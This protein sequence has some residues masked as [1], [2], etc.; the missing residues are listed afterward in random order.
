MNIKNILGSFIVVL[1]G[2][3]FFSSLLLIFV[4]DNSQKSALWLG[5]YQINRN[6]NHLNRAIALDPYNPD[7]WALV[8][9][10]APEALPARRI[11]FSLGVPR[12]EASE[13]SAP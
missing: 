8:P 13:M 11:G 10:G 1:A 12:A 3:L 9:E 5:H 6:V 2:V 4:R 7:L